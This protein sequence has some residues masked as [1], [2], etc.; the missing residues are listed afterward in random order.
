MIIVAV[1][2]VLYC[3]FSFPSYLYLIHPV[4]LLFVCML[5]VGHLDDFN[6]EAEF[7]TH[8][9]IRRMSGGQKVRLV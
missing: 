3:L 4:D 6:L 7:G 9:S 1:I 2:T 5:L 8:G